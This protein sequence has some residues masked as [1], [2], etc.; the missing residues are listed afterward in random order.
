MG[1]QALAILREHYRHAASELQY[2]SPLQLLVAVI[3]SAQSTDRQVNQVTSKLFA[4]CPDAATLAATPLPQLEELIKGVGLYRHK[5]KHLQE[6]ARILLAKHQGEVPTTFTELEALP[7]V[8]HKTAGVVLSIAYN[9]PALPVDTHVFRVAN[10][11]GLGE[12]KT[13]A[14]VEASL[15]RWIPQEDWAKAHHWLLHH[16]RYCCTARNPH[17][18]TCPIAQL[19]KERISPKEDLK[20]SV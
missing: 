8:G 18:P 5:A 10:R 7:G 16:G 14:A 13:V 3:L 2:T 9:I 4:L 11:T 20:Y 17:C 12:G 19:C 6:M 1:E 15:T